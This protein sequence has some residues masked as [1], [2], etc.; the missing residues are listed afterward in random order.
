M[1]EKPSIPL[2][3]I[4][5]AR[6]VFKPNFEGRAEKF[7]DPGNRY[8]NV[9]IPQDMVP[10]LMSDGWNVKYTKETEEWEAKPYLEV[11]VAFS[12]R[13]PTIVLN[14]AGHETL[15]NEQTCASLDFLQFEKFDVAIRPYQWENDMGSGVK[16]YLQ[17]LY[18]FPVSDGIM[19]K[20][21]RL[22]A[23]AGNVE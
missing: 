13:P 8:F 1:A 6:F 10:R 2:I 11:K 7:N 17:T 12:Y 9:E 3:E 5:D 18:A 21:A 22:R 4:E 14:R 19:N 16:A 15:I 20:Y 23:E